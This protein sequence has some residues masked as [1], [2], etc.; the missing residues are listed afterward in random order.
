MVFCLAFCG[1]HFVLTVHACG[2]HLSI[3][4][5]AVTRMPLQSGVW[6]IAEIKAAIMAVKFTYYM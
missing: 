5:L 4:R 2:L 3:V 1:A 6:S